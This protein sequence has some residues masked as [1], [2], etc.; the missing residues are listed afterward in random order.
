LAGL[1]KRFAYPHIR[2]GKGG[3][4]IIKAVAQMEAEVKA[5]MN[6]YNKAYA[7]RDVD[8]VV[9]LLAPVAHTLRKEPYR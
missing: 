1:S 6:Q 2:Q 4:K 8:G 7:K 3:T 5:V 9:A